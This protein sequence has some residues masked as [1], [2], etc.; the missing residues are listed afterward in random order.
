MWIL[1]FFFRCQNEPRN[2]FSA[3][4]CYKWYDSNSFHYARLYI[5]LDYRIALFEMLPI[6]AKYFDIS[7]L[8][9]V[10][11][12]RL[13]LVCFP[14]FFRG[15]KVAFAGEKQKRHS[16]DFCKCGNLKINGNRS[17]IIGRWE[18]KRT[19]KKAGVTSSMPSISKKLSTEIRKCKVQECLSF[20]TMNLDKLQKHGFEQIFHVVYVDFYWKL[21]NFSIW[22]Y[23]NRADTRVDYYDKE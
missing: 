5:T 12:Y 19:R 11:M 22:K 8:K 15:R 14:I 7:V 16:I 3:V 1:S 10:T 20:K 13:Y 2:Q 21:L 6:N 18:N 9:K 4:A 17:C 23:K